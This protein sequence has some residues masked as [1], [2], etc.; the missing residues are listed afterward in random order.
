MKRIIVYILS[1]IGGA[2][3]FIALPY[4]CG[5]SAPI[6]VGLSVLY[7]GLSSELYRWLFE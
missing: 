4:L 5:V 6:S 2:F 3:L 1:L 7:G